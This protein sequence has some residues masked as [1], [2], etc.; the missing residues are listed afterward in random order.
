MFNCLINI[1]TTK[2]FYEVQ[3]KI[4]SNWEA[5]MDRYVS[6]GHMTKNHDVIIRTDKKNR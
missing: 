5:M 3:K 1:D 2:N 6:S 4:L